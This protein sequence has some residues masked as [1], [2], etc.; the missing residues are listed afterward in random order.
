M[1]FAFLAGAA[2]VLNIVG[3]IVYLA[4]C[5]HRLNRRPRV[6]ARAEIV[7]DIPF[8]HRLGR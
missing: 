5:V 8:S 2:V 7:G 1:I 4:D 3:G 6:S